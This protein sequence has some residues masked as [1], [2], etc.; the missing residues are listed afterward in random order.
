MNGLIFLFV[1][2]LYYA[3]IY[4]DVETWVKNNSVNLKCL[5]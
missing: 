2:I 4:A 3:G 5:R 1:V